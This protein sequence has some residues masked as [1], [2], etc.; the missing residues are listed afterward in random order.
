[1]PTKARPEN[2]IIARFV[3]AYEDDAW[4]DARLTF[5]D[6]VIDGGV[7]GLAERA[8]GAILA[9]EH[10]I[11]EPFVGDIMDQTEMVPLFPLIESDKSLIVPNL[12]IN[13]FIS[14]GTFHRRKASTREV[15]MAAV[16][17]WLRTN[18]LTLPKGISKHTCS[19]IGVRYV[20]DF[21][22]ALTIKVVDLPGGGTIRVRRQQVGNTFDQVVE[23]LFAKKLPKLVGTIATKRV[24]LLERRH[25][26]HTPEMILDEIARQRTKFPQLA[27]VDEIWI[28][29]TI[30][31][32]D[33]YLDFELYE[34]NVVV[35]GLQFHGQTLTAK[36]ENGQIVFNA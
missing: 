4:R 23:R 25:M 30:G 16:H 26:N 29:E 1:M 33:G 35:K 36:V 34:N 12:G 15:M 10:T 13:V 7:D 31:Y 32:Q 21:G 18:R 8:D 14:T 28:V 11:V 19:V 5:P 2:Q 27:N 24:L 22:L 20:S 9:I 17:R 6:E 3:S